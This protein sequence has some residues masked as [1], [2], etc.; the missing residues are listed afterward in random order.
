MSG[1][2]EEGGKR[3]TVK[4]PWM[5]DPGSWRMIGAF[6]IGAVLTTAV[7][8]IVFIVTRA[9][10]TLQAPIPVVP[11]PTVA[12]PTWTSSD[13]YVNSSNAVI[14][15]FTTHMT[16][17]GPLRIYRIIS[18]GGTF[19]TQDFILFPPGTIKT[20]DLPAVDS[21]ND[22]LYQST[23]AFCSL[24]PVDIAGCVLTIFQDG[25]MLIGTQ[26]TGIDGNWLENNVFPFTLIGTTYQSISIGTQVWITTFGPGPTVN[27]IQQSINTTAP[28]TASAFALRYKGIHGF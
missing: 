9:P 26:T 14:A 5:K 28:T 7:I 11:G 16:R 19:L 3:S 24:G 10:S 15:N 18:A 4:I 17:F 13:G 8:W 21:V 23:P 1:V 2:V 20:A 6:L 12:N 22:Y 25:S 27:A